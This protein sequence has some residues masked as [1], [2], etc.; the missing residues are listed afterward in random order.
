L[1]PSDRHNVI[2]YLT[3]EIALVPF[4]RAV[5][6]PAAAVGVLPV[7][8][9]FAASLAGAFVPGFGDPVRL[10]FPSFWALLG[11]YAPTQHHGRL[12][13]VGWAGPGDYSISRLDY[14]KAEPAV[15]R[16][17]PFAVLSCSAVE[18]YWVVVKAACLGD[19]G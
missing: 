13:A 4:A 9:S 18:F 6:V 17:A 11:G 10:A 15:G 5:D 2:S 8:D 14:G 19:S 12:V 7:V 1:A 16:V 3:P